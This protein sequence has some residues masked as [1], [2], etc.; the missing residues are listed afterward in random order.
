MTMLQPVGM[1]IWA[2]FTKEILQTMQSDCHENT[3]TN[4]YLVGHQNDVTL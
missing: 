1:F 4:Q 2:G 3:V